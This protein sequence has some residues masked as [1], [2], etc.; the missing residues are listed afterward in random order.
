[1]ND[2]SALLT[3]SKADNAASQRSVT[4]N[5]LPKIKSQKPVKKGQNSPILNGLPIVSA[6][7]C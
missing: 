6:L 1:M 2:L 3:A 5:L 7:G 4:D